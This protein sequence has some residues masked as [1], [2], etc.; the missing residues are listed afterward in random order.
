MTFRSQDLKYL[1]DEHG[2]PLTLTVKGDQ[3]MIPSTGTVTGS[4][5][6][7]TVQTYFYNYNLS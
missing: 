3:L 6:D 7:Y 5:T 1:I 4:E 2:K